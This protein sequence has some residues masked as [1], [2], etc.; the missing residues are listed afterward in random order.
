MFTLFINH[1]VDTLLLPLI[2]DSF[3]TLNCCLV[4]LIIP[5]KILNILSIV[6][7]ILPHLLFLLSFILVL[8]HFNFHFTL[9]H[10]IHNFPPLR[11]LHLHYLLAFPFVLLIIL[12]LVICFVVFKT[13]S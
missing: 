11:N 4:H 1:Q 3:P 13:T 8:F 10:L 6:H 9:L 12:A 2:P 7:S 5:C